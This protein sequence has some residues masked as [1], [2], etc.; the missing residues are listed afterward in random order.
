MYDFERLARDSYD[1][2]AGWHHSWHWPKD[3]VARA[4]IIR[5]EGASAARDIR[6]K[7]EDLHRRLRDAERAAI[8]AD[9]WLRDSFEDDTI[10]PAAPV[11][12]GTEKE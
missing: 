3:S 10:T 6:R 9:N 12:P 5:E 8:A 7:I 4:K 2:W 11:H 1:G